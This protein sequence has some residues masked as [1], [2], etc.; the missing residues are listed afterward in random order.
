[1]SKHLLFHIRSDKNQSL[2]SDP[3]QMTFAQ[4]SF[5]MA[6]CQEATTGDKNELDLMG[7]HQ[8]RTWKHYFFL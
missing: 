5:N 3:S 2:N 6:T 8:T 4:L 1:M 7:D